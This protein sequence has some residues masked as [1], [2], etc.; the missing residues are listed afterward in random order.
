MTRG[1]SERRITAKRANGCTGVLIS[2]IAKKQCVLLGFRAQRGV[3]FK[4]TSKRLQ[5][6]AFFEDDAAFASR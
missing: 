1:A 3:D 4:K 6:G 2:R 5:S